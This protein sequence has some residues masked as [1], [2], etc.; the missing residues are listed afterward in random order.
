[1]LIKHYFH[2][3]KSEE[4]KFYGGRAVAKFET[5]FRRE[6]PLFKNNGKTT[7]NEMARHNVGRP[8]ML[9]RL[10]RGPQY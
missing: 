2:I 10:L 3:E 9:G 4:F 7:A 6:V 1:M 5:K 8:A